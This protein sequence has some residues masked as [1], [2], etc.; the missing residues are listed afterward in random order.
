LFEQW[1]EKK[2]DKGFSPAIVF[3]AGCFLRDRDRREQSPSLRK[4]KSLVAY[5][6]GLYIF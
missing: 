3:I 5:T 2:N 6:T 1:E 4:T